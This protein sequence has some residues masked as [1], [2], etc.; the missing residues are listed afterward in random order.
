MTKQNKPKMYMWLTDFLRLC[1]ASAIVGIFCGVILRSG[2]EVIAFIG[3]MLWF[4]IVPILV[5][6][7][8]FED[9]P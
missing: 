1:F 9:A 3:V 2:H 4:T 7:R 6:Q 5:K 8:M